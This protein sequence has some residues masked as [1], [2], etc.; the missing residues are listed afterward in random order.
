MM[1]HYQKW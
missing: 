1:W